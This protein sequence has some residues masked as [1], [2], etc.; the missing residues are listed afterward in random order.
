MKRS[1]TLPQLMFVVGSRVV[2]GAGIGL[3]AADRLPERI[4]RRVG[5]SLVL[6]GAIT[7]LP[8]AMIVAKARPT[9]LERAADHAHVLVRSLQPA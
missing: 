7:T 8:A 9:L 6:I 2:L 4:R 3:L 1:L 5:V